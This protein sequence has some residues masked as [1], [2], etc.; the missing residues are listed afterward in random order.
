MKTYKCDGCPRKQKACFIRCGDDV[1]PQ[2]CIES[3]TDNKLTA[4]WR[5]FHATRK[6]S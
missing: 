5:V 4:T 1:K 6:D 2:G 3:W